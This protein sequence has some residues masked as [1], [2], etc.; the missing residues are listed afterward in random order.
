MKRKDK[1]L[2][3]ALHL[4][5]KRGVSEVGVREIAREID[6]S[7]GNLSYHFPKKEDI[8]VEL[9]NRMSSKNNEIYSSYFAQ[10]PSLKGHLE[11]AAGVFENNFDHRGILVGNAEIK[12]IT[13]SAFNYKE[14]RGRRFDGLKRIFEGLKEAGELTLSPEDLT[15]LVGM[16]GLFFRFWLHEA[17]VDE[18]VLVKE[19]LLPMYLKRWS[20][21][22]SLFATEQGKASINQFWI[23]K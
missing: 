17:F 13:Q 5:N 8:I 10:S 14:V 20:W 23:D 19:E 2:E 22:L 16:T 6:I 9:L 11:L 12:K 1:I 3:V 18:L 4:F 7:A 21:Q 15:H